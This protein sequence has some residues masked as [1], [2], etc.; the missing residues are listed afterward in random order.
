MN[1]SGATVAEVEDVVAVYRDLRRRF[2][3]RSTTPIPAG[4]Y[5]VRYVVDTERPD[6][7]ANGPIKAAAVRGTVAVR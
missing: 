5:T 6:L 3:L 4:T 7:P 1:A 2:L